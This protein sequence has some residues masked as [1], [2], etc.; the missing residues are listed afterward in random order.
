MQGPDIALLLK[1]PIVIHRCCIRRKEL[2]LP[3]LTLFVEYFD[4]LEP[5]RLRQ[6]VQL[7]QVTKRA[8]CPSQQAQLP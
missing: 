7:T 4:A 6:S 3:T 5:A 1:L 8:L 2:Q